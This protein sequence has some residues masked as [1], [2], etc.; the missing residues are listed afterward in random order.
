MYEGPAAA[1]GDN[2]PVPPV[3]TEGV[4]VASV[5]M[6]AVVV[7]EGPTAGDGTMTQ[8]GVLAPPSTAAAARATRS[9]CSHG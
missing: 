6:G 2:V 8:T 4:A 5:E 3:V 9:H 1:A 7:Y